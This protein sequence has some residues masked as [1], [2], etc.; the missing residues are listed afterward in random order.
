MI[1][2]KHCLQMD[3]CVKFSNFRKKCA[4]VKDLASGYAC[5]GEWTKFNQ[6][7]LTKVKMIPIVG[8]WC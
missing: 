6:V 4:I 5:I 8:F 7:Q 3:V 2:E 1:R